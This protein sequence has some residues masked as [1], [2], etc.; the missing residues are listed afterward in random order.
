[1]EKE[2]IKEIMEEWEKRQRELEIARYKDEIEAFR[3]WH[4]EEAKCKIISNIRSLNRLGVTGIDLLAC[5]L[6]NARLENIKLAGGNL[7]RANLRNAKLIKADLRRVCFSYA[8]LE[9]SCL[10]DSNM[11]GSDFLKTNLQKAD[12]RGV[13]MK[14]AIFMDTDFREA[15]GLT[16]EQLSMVKTL[17]MSRFDPGLNGELMNRYPGLFTHPDLQK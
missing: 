3:W 8:D 4:S 11:E 7:F 17:F 2:L 16:V 9:G 5:H 14:G 15:E 13:N 10:H 12:F 1:M 6:E